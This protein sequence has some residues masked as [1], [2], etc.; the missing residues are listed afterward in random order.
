M[1]KL[2]A[3]QKAPNIELKTLAGEPVAL[4]SL[5]GNGRSSVLL[6]FLRHLA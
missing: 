1:A 5:W 6:I 2:K 3:G 4:D